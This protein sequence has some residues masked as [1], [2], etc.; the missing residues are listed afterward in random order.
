VARRPHR[1]RRG[2]GSTSLSAAYLQRN[3]GRRSAPSRSTSPASSFRNRSRPARRARRLRRPD[4]AG[5]Q[6]GVSRDDGQ[7]A[8]TPA[9][10]R[11]TYQ[12]GLQTLIWKADDEND[13]DLVYNLLYRREGETSWKVLRRGATDSILV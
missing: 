5:S 6:A 12:K 4:D 1:Q 3:I 2:A 7:T 13:D 8:N 10:G 11:R 9:L